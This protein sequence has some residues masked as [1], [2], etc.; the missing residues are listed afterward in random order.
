MTVEESVSSA[1]AAVREDCPGIH[2]DE[3]GFHAYARARPDAVHWVDLC[4]AYAALEGDPPACRHVRTQHQ[5]LIDTAMNRAGLTAPEVSDASQGL[6]SKLLVADPDGTAARL[7][8]YH[9]SGPLSAWLRICATREAVDARRRRRAYEPL[10]DITEQLVATSGDLEHA[11]AV[12]ES[13]ERVQE[14]LRATLIGLPVRFQNVLRHRFI[15][16]LTSEDLAQL[17][18]VHRATVDRWLIR[19]RDTVL[20]GTRRRL[21]LEL[22]LRLDSALSLINAVVGRLEMSFSTL[23]AN[24]TTPEDL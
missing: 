7:D 23:A 16:R 18:G 13:R 15:D 14:A 1:L 24:D 3:A 22:D 17:Y 5:R 4:L 6:W 11:L 8:R 2:V 12:A 9:G 20:R 10:S 19:A 21:E